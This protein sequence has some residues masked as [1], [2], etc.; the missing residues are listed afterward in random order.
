M[1]NAVAALG[2]V[3]GLALCTAL[4]ASAA[5][6][7]GKKY[8]KR[9][10]AEYDL[11]ADVIQKLASFK[12]SAPQ[13]GESMIVNMVGADAVPW[14]APGFKA[15]SSTNPY[16][17]VITVKGKAAE[18]GDVSTMWQAGWRLD[19]GATRLSVVPG[20][21]KS[22][23]RSGEAVTLTASAAPVSFK[24]D[25]E[26]GAYVGMVNARN[27]VIDSVR[28]QVWSGLANPS[29]W[30]TVLSVQGLLVGLVFLGLAWWFKR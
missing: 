23:L 2:M 13:Q 6:D 7:K 15:N 18:S 22:G 5:D 27:L 3:L 4:T 30:Q 24:V 20:L 14:N 28:V 8:G 12:P 26:V 17:I 9:I 10:V 11:P 19:D 21:S 1:R 25:R 29:I 16:V